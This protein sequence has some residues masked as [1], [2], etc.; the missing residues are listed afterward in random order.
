MRPELF[1]EGVRAGGRT[2][3]QTNM[4]KLIVAFRNFVNAPKNPH[5]RTDKSINRNLDALSKFSNSKSIYL[6]KG[7]T[8]FELNKNMAL[9]NLYNILSISRSDLVPTAALKF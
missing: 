3:R 7:V 5:H 8:F 2:D 4:T 6:L 1:H 9:L